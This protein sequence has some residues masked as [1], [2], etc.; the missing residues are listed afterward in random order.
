VRFFTSCCM[1]LSV[2]HPVICGALRSFTKRSFLLSR[3]NGAPF[4]PAALGLAWGVHESVTENVLSVMDARKES[5]PFRRFYTA[6]MTELENVIIAV[7]AS[8]VWLVCAVVV[9]ASWLLIE[10]LIL[11]PTLLLAVLTSAL[12]HLLGLVA[13]ITKVC[14][15]RRS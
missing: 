7:I 15:C 11:L 2:V 9:G 14:W 5:S 13:F 6:D 10:L 4:V 3:R 12:F 1:V 8:A